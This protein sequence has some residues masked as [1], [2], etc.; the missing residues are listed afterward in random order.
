ME[1]VDGRD[2]GG[3]GATGGFFLWLEVVGGNS[4]SGGGRMINLAST[5]TMTCFVR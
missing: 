5:I 2:V 3:E 1:S 4:V